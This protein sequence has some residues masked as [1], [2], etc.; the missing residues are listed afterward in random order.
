MDQL[1]FT[2]LRLLQ[3]DGRMT[4]SELS[5]R[6]ALSRP[7]VAERLLRLQERGVITGFRAQIP[8]SAVGRSI[9]L[10]IQI[11]ELKAAP[12][13]FEKRIAADEAI[14]ECHRVTG[15]V[16]YV[17]KAAVSGMEAL[18]QLVERLMPY[19]NVNTSVIL[20]SPV[21]NRMVLP[22]QQK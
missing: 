4:I 5:K 7:S 11:S 22:Q 2:I 14:L 18:T 10:I 21:I 3:E 12:I 19:G 1:D 20:S 13:E 8:P 16:S 15:T 17:M 9:Q 6:V